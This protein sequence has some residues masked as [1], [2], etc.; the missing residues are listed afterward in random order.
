MARS[1]SEESGIAGCGASSTSVPSIELNIVNATETAG[2]K[3]KTGAT[4]AAAATEIETE[5]DSWIAGIENEESVQG[6]L[7]CSNC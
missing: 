5:T 2:A 4:A 7:S 1:I 6:R 3:T